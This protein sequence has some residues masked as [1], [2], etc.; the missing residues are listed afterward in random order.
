MKFITQP[1]DTT[2]AFFDIKPP[3][4]I[5]FSVKELF[6]YYPYILIILFFVLLFYLYSRFFSKQSSVQVKNKIELPPDVVFL[7]RV[8]LLE[9]KQ[10]ISKKEYQFFYIEL[11]EIFRGFIEARFNVLALESST[12]ELKI[13]LSKLKIKDDWIFSFLR[14]S[15]IVKFAKGTPNDDESLSFLDHQSAFIKKYKTQKNSEN[16]LNNKSNKLS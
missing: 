14:V 4:D 7:N 15:D 10:Y 16:K 11:S 13:L 6:R 1:L 8:K 9:E 12:H 3:K 5:K 2:S